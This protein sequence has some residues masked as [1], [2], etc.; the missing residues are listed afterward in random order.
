MRLW[1]EF[2]GQVTLIEHNDICVFNWKIYFN[3]SYL[4][5]ARDS[6][7]FSLFFHRG[8]YVV[9]IRIVSPAFMKKFTLSFYLYI[10][11]SHVFYWKINTKLVYFL[12]HHVSKLVYRNVTQLL[13]AIHTLLSTYTYYLEEYLELKNHFWILI[14]I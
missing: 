10:H 11:N 8:H 5:I 3:S 7:L 2:M 13:I 14:Y 4:H 1:F 6:W 9:E 12:S